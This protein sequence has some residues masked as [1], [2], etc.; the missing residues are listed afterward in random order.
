[1][2]TC[3]RFL[4]QLKDIRAKLA[5]KEK[6]LDEKDKQ[7]EKEAEEEEKKMAKAARAGPRGSI[8]SLRD[9]EPISWRMEKQ[10]MHLIQVTI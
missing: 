3:F 9:K 2:Q 4:H 1:M 6:Q 7:K 8:G 5:E 10:V